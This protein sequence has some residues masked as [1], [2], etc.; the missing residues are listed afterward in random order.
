MARYKKPQ[1]S[2]GLFL[3]VSL[4]HHLL[5]GTFVLTLPLLFDEKINLGI[6]DMRSTT[7]QTGATAIAPRILL[8]IMLYCYSCGVISSHK[9]A[10]MCRNHLVVKALAEN[11]EPHYTTLSNFVSGMGGKY[12]G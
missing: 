2:Q 11:I 7:N 3:T 1:K 6:F 4:A 5:P 8:N 10:A 9:I 12:R